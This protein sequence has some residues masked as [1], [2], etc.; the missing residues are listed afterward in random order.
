MLRTLVVLA[1][2]GLS[3]AWAKSY[4]ITLDSATK[5]GNVELKP[6]KYS[7]SVMDDTKVKFI[8]SS[9][10]AVEASAKVTTTDKKFQATQIDLKQ[11][12]GTAQ[13]NE[14]DLGGTKTKILFE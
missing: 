3:A 11:V 13:V 12:N 1:A 14:I 4:D 6:G 5:V 10:Q 9:G 8:S 2:L 7:L